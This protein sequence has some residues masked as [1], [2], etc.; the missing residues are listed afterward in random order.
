[1]AQG[2]D[3]RPKTLYARFMGL[4]RVRVCSPMDARVDVRGRD[5]FESDEAAAW[6]LTPHEATKDG[7]SLDRDSSIPARWTAASD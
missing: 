7:L 4:R 6:L 1:M 5:R 3:G 2:L